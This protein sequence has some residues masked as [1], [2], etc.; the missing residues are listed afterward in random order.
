MVELGVGEG[1]RLGL[2]LD[3]LD[4]P[5]EPGRGGDLL[6]RAAEH[7]GA[8]VEPDDA[9]SPAFDQR[10]ADQPGAAGDVENAVLGA[11]RDGL[12]RRLPPARILEEAERGAEL[13][14]VGG[15]LLEHLESVLLAL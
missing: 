15:E 2:A 5:R 9:A 13:V 11:R 3:Q 8:L 7:R 14:V 12:D 6:P 10:L 1:E 4:P